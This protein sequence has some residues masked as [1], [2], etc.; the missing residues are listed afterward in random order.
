MRGG[1]EEVSG[2]LG[3]PV[4]VRWG[5]GGHTPSERGG[6]TGQCVF[7]GGPPAISEE[8]EAHSGRGGPHGPM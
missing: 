7:G 2:G 4:R 8:I 1:I 3:G 6:P 5:C